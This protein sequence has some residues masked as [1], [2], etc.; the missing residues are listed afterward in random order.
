MGA[1]HP[2]AIHQVE[3]AFPK[4]GNSYFGIMEI[5]IAQQA[6]IVRRAIA[7]LMLNKQASPQ[8]AISSY[9]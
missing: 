4:K 2:V 7:F 9:F 6:G 5:A 1:V 8:A 3:L